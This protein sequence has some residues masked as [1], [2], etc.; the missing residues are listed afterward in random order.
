M[1]DVTNLGL[2]TAKELL[3]RL[4]NVRISESVDDQFE[5][6]GTLEVWRPDLSYFVPNRLL[7]LNM[8]T[9]V[10]VKETTEL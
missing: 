5:K 8:R 6:T 3:S 4:I 2:G 7:F 1:L 10:S 9:T